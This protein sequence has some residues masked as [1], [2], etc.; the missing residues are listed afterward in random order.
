MEKVMNASCILMG[1][2]A[3]VSNV[4]VEPEAASVD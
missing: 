2:A 1:L 4:L 3:A